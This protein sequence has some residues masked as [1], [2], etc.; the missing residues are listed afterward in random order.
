MSRPTIYAL[1]TKPGRAAIGVIR[2]SGLHASHVYKQLTKSQSLPLHRTASLRSLYGSKGVLDHALTLFFK[3]PKLYTGEDLLELHVHG[4]T[5]IVKAVM[6]AVGKMHRPAD[7]IHVR[8]AEQGEFSK[9]AF[10]NGRLD[11]T[12]L[13]GVREMIDAETESQRVGALAS[14][15]GSNL[16]LMRRWRHDIVKNVALLTT[17]IDFGEEHDLEETNRLFVDVEK[18][19]KS[20]ANEIRAYLAK[21]R[22]L[23]ILMRGIKVTL[24]GPPNAGKLSLLNYLASDEKAIVSEVAGTTRDVIDVPLD[25][26]GYKIV[27]GDTAGIRAMLDAGQIEQEGIKRAKQ[28]ALLGDIVLV[29]VP[30][31]EPLSSDIIAHVQLLHDAKRHVVA[32]LNKIDLGHPN[33]AKLT[34]KLAQTLEILEQNVFPA[35]CLTG[36][37][38]DPLRDELVLLF[39]RVSMS[40]SLDPVVISARARDLLENDVLYG[41]E[42]FLVWK[43]A[44]DVVLASECLRQAS[45]GIGKITGDAVGVEEILGVV[46]SKFCIGK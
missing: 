15:T 11:L 40:T 19:I 1:S 44:E 22:G 29:V 39:K 2:V 24:M 42:Q 43:D 21:V 18:D 37:G 34:S 26:A 36:E 8:Y 41:L 17:V 38:M 33:M 45:E 35:S 46:F 14:L 30:V 23:E 7:E 28:K 6:A 3:G 9:R 16:A 31:N 32:V 20:L 25:I 4:G 10:L 5:A 27:V 13:E 12:E